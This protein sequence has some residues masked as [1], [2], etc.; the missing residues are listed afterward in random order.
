MIETHP[1]TKP[2][3]DNPVYW[4]RG[5]RFIRLYY[6]M[7]EEHLLDLVGNDEIKVS[8]PDEC[9]D[10]LEF[11]SAEME[12]KV[13]SAS[14]YG[15]ISFTSHFGSSLMWSHYAD[16]HKGAC[17]R[18]DFPVNQTGGIQIPSIYNWENA[19]LEAI[20]KNSRDFQPELVTEYAACEKNASVESRQ[21]MEVDDGKIVIVKVRYNDR[22]PHEEKRGLYVSYKNGEIRQFG[23]DPRMFTKSLEWQYEKEWRIFVNLH[24]AASFHD[25]LFFVRGLTQYITKIILG[26]KFHMRASLME[27]YIGRA[28]MNNPCEYGKSALRCCKV[29]QAQYHPEKYEITIRTSILE[30]D[31]CE[32]LKFYLEK[33]S[34]A[35]GEVLVMY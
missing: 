27:N 33:L 32:L 23:L 21:F 29:E 9:N 2:T 25:R 3:V 11:L 28:A 5:Q 20:S 15:F 13:E 35:E 24:W 17:L 7:P 22:R 14:E 34:M 30:N 18:F 16:A 19:N 1:D 12:G 31:D 10:P 8:I 4:F 26:T 6:F